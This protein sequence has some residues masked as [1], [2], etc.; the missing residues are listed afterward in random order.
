MTAQGNRRDVQS[1]PDRKEVKEALES[2][3]G[4]DTSISNTLNTQTYYYAV[5]LKDG[6]IL[7]LSRE[8]QTIFQQAAAILP[9]SLLV[10]IGCT[11]Q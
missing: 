6:G 11:D 4:E 7:R 10:M 2:G 1:C 9:Y 8:T 5:R 3:E